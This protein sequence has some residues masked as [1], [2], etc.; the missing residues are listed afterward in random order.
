MA[1][2]DLSPQGAAFRRA[3]LD[4]LKTPWEE[5]LLAADLGQKIERLR[6]WLCA[7][8]GYHTCPT[9]P[10]PAG[11]PM[12]DDTILGALQEALAAQEESGLTITPEGPDE[13]QLEGQ[14]NLRELAATI[15]PAIDARVSEVLAAL[16]AS[17]E[18]PEGLALELEETDD[19]DTVEIDDHV[20]LRQLAETMA[21]ILAPDEEDFEDE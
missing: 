11:D 4:V 8:S 21:G 7:S 3:V 10:G 14:L 18:G 16:R 19:A 6:A 5:L 2:S 9:Q 15:A 1:H 12:L 13:M 17:L 20:D